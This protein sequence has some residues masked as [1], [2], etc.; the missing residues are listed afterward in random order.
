MKKLLSITLSLL[1]VC[2]SLIIPVSAEEDVDVSR[3]PFVYVHGFLGWGS[4]SALEEKSP[5]W[6]T[7]E[8]DNVMTY[9]RDNGFEVYNPTVSPIASAWDRAC[10]LYAELTGTVVDYGAAHSAKY[11]HERY[12]RDY[13]GKSVMG[14]GWD[15]QTKLNLVGHSYGGA[16]VRVFAG[17]LAYGDTDEIAATGSETSELFKGG[18]KDLIYSIT[19]L[20]SPT[21][22]STLSD[23]CGYFPP[24]TA[25]ACYYFSSSH[26]S[27]FNIDA[28]LDQW[29]LTA[30][31]D[32]EQPTVSFLKCLK[33]AFSND[34]C[35][36]DMS[37]K[38]ALEINER[39]P[40][41]D[42]VYYFSYCGDVTTEDS[43]GFYSI[44]N[45]ENVMDMFNSLELLM[46][47][48]VGYLSGGIWIDKSWGRSDGMVS[49]NSAMYPY[50]DASTHEWYADA[51]EIKTGVWYVMPILYGVDHYDYCS[52]ANTGE[53]G[54]REEYFNFFVEL[55]EKVYAL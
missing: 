38:G 6:G 46:K 19:T 20:A 40:T 1:F 11:G 41:I 53:L 44:E 49:L 35:A 24:L 45:K 47:Y 14:D 50:G 31:P 9:L 29:G 55:M 48:H 28:M 51:T 18:H 5:Y 23:F 15:L 16:T 54:T 25:I 43:L 12:G 3:Y 37:V 4:N 10:E 7:T 22:G 33:C 27:G 26:D 30:P 52:A 21:N 13:T 32:E 36:Y 17:L 8:E 34:H 2:M 39:F 42:S